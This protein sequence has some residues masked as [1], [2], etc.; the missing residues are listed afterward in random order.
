[1]IYTIIDKKLK[2]RQKE[3]YMG[4]YIYWLIL[5]GITEYI[6]YISFISSI[7]KQ[8]DDDTYIKDKMYSL[9]LKGIIS[10]DIKHIITGIIIISYISYTIYCIIIHDNLITC[11]IL[12]AILVIINRKYITSIYGN[13]AAVTIYLN[14]IINSIYIVKEICIV[15]SNNYQ[16]YPESIISYVIP[17]VVFISI[18]Y[19]FFF[20]RY[21][22]YRRINMSKI[23]SL[24]IITTWGCRF[25][26]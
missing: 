18:I 12:A 7:T 3:K 8:V 13:V 17:F 25:N 9:K 20:I 21:N 1:M 16:Y 23:T 2:G 10:S 11:F 15:K 6:I 22:N 26:E 14:V 19:I 4:M 5:F 24:A